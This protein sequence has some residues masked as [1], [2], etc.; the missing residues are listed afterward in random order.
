[1]IIGLTGYA[2]SGKDTVASILVEKY[3]FERVAFADPIRSMLMDIDPLID[4]GVRVSDIVNQYGWEIAKAKPEVRRL[5]Q[6]LGVSARDNL[7]NAVWVT[8]ALRQ[9][10]DEQ[11]YVITDVRFINEAT[12]LQSI[13]G[14]I[15]RVER[16]GVVAVNSHVSES[17][18][19]NYIVD[20]IIDNSG[21][22]E[23]LESL[24][25]ARLQA[26]YVR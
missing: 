18:M 4:S 3:K 20:C 10:V 17:E 6:T 11:D 19:D 21:A 25:A 16:P 24:V 14:Q 13:H 1:M 8:A 5:L 9:M 22:L 7:D 23:S 2:R 12:M 15:W 26:E